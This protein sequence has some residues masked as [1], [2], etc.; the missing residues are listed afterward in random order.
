MRCEGQP[1][2]REDTL[3][4]R[5]NLEPLPFAYQPC[6]CF[7]SFPDQHILT[8][9]VWGLNTSGDKIKALKK[10]QIIGERDSYYTSN[11]SHASFNS[12]M[13]LDFHMERQQ[14]CWVRVLLTKR[15]VSHSFNSFSR[16]AILKIHTTPT[17]FSFCKAP[18]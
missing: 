13:P 2:K 9:P 3:R 17:A 10:E 12:E 18:H 1:R 11:L 14:W 5:A 6:D 7:F 15:Q 16:F 8:T 4:L